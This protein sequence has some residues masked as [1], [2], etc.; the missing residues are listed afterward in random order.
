MKN[1]K[2]KIKNILSILKNKY[3]K[4]ECALIRIQ[5]LLT[6]FFKENSKLNTK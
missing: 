4:I 3:D 5:K 2:K 6:H 1:K